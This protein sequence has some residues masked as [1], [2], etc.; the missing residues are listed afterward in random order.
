MSNPLFKTP[1]DQVDLEKKNSAALMQGEALNAQMDATFKTP[2][3]KA[4]AQQQLVDHVLNNP[5]LREIDRTRLY[6]Q[7]MAR[8]AYLSGDMK[9]RVDANK[10]VIEET[11]AA[12]ASA[13]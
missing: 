6:S 13:R 12:L 2:N 5:D 9:E 7:G 1:Q 11:E 4:L 3:G 8:L 10:K